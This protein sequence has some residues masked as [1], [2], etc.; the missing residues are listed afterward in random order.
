MADY[1]LY[2]AKATLLTPLHIGSGRD[3]LLSYDFAVHNG[4]TWRLNEDAIL[5]AQNVDDPRVLERL[6]A[7]PPAQLLKKEDFREGSPFFRYTL[8]DVPRSLAEGAQLK[9]L[10]KDPYDRPYLPGTSLKGAIRTALAWYAWKELGLRPERQ[11]LGRNPRFAAQNYER[12]IFGDNPNHDLLRALHVG[13]SEPAGADRLIVINARV[14]HRSG[15]MAS[16]IELEAVASETTF[17]LTVKLDTA[18]FSE[19]AQRHGLKMRGADWLRALPAIVNRHT[20][21]RIE[22]ERRWF[23]DVPGAER[24][25]D[26]YSKLAPPSHG[27]LLQVGWGTGWDDKTFGSRLRED[28]HFLEG[29]LRPRRENGYGIARGRRRPG[30]PFPKSRRVVFSIQR[31]P[32]GRV[33]ERPVAPLGWVWVEWEEAR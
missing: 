20:A 4:R 33:L 24:V 5:D 22:E 29:I 12:K 31:A 9:E 8:R 18:L 32:D 23:A 25:R 27:F 1:I 11:M 6:M 2:S 13:D 16:P 30:D 28:P 26:F 14:L 10:W 19:W 3:L 21:Q 7:I 17:R 15:Q